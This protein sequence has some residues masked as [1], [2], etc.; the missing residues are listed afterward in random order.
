M[1]AKQQQ[2]IA[3]L[4]CCRVF[5]KGRSKLRDLARNLS[6]LCW[7]TWPVK[8]IHAAALLGRP[9]TSCIPCCAFANCCFNKFSAARG[10]AGSFTFDG[11]KYP[12]AILI[13]AVTWSP[14]LVEQGRLLRPASTL[15]S[16][17]PFPACAPHALSA[18]YLAARAGGAIHQRSPRRFLPEHLP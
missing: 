17:P 18:P 4:G 8:F 1:H 7:T 10:F 16:E 3:S 15:S 5:E 11:D 2:L 14:H 6:A 13:V 12:S 9:P